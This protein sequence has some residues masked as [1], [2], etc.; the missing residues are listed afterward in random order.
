MREILGHPPLFDPTS[1]PHAKLEVEEKMILQVAETNHKDQARGRRPIWSKK[2]PLQPPPGMVG[3]HSRRW[4]NPRIRASA[5]PPRHLFLYMPP[6]TRDR[7]HEIAASPHRQCMPPLPSA[8]WRDG[9]HHRHRYRRRQWPRRWPEDVATSVGL[10]TPVSSKQ[11][12]HGRLIGRVGGDGGGWRL[13][14]GSPPKSPQFFPT[15]CQFFLSLL[16]AF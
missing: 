13:R 5:P 8:V 16:K 1:S 14:S 11:G 3:T 15:C 7:R 9:R 4:G 10:G 12:L 2:G 6:T